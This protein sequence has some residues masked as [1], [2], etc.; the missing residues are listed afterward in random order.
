MN[1]LLLLPRAE[2]I[3]HIYDRTLAARFPEL[4]IDSVE[5]HEDV[6]PFIAHTDVLLTFSPFMADHV[7]H[8]A[9]RLKWIQVLGSGVD[10]IVNLPSLRKD[11]L[12]TNGR[13]VQAIPVSECAFALMLALSRGMQRMFVNQVERHWERWPSQVLRGRTLGILGVGEIAEELAAKAKA[14]G[15]RVIGIS[16]SPRSVANFDRMFAREHLASAVRELDYLV[17]LTPHSTQTHHIVDAEVLANMRPTAFLIN[18]ARGGVLNETDLIAALRAETIRGAALDVFSEEPLPASSELWS[19]S[20]V[21]ISPHLAGLNSSYPD[22]ILPLIE[23]N[24]RLFL[25]GRRHEMINVV[26]PGTAES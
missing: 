15:M 21:L 7:A 18:V 14:F 2:N 11:V 12:V 10:G 13:G 1:L 20:N 24:I 9:T 23:Q 19:L 26:V 4:H 3:D 6:G 25:A 17:L 22:S 16:S 8:S 5:R